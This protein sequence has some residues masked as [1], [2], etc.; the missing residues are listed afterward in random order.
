MKANTKLLHP[1][2]RMWCVLCLK[3]GS[4]AWQNRRRVGMQC[5]E[6]A[7]GKSIFSHLLFNRSVLKPAQN[8]IKPKMRE[9]RAATNVFS[10]D[11]RCSSGVP[12]NT[13][14]RENTSQERTAWIV[15]L[16]AEYQMAGETQ[17]DTSKLIQERKKKKVQSGF[18]LKPIFNQKLWEDVNNL[19][20][21][22]NNRKPE[23]SKIL[24]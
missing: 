9:V 16:N 17:T 8:D 18:I 4:S 15:D 14:K 7:G 1:V 6:P 23:Q 11:F 12:P 3:P 21:L 2:S 24:L 19:E 13:C 22:K 5:N 20:L 10:V